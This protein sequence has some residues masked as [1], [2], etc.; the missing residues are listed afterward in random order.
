MKVFTVPA[1]LFCLI[2]SVAFSQT[3][4]LDIQLVREHHIFERSN[5]LLFHGGFL[6]AGRTGT[7]EEA[8]SFVEIFDDSG[9]MIEAVRLEHSMRNFEAAGPCRMVAVGLLA[10]T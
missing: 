8:A 5:T 4:D 9:E 2:S 10:Y 6:F 7:S 3:T 1:I